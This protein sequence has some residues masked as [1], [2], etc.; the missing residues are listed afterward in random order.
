MTNP[1]I[2]V[3]DWTAEGFYALRGVGILHAR[4]LRRTVKY[5]IDTSR[6]GPSTHMVV[7]RPIHTPLRPPAITPL[8][9]IDH[10]QL[11]SRP[12]LSSIFTTDHVR[13]N[14][15]SISRSTHYTPHHYLLQHATNRGIGP[16]LLHSSLHRSI[17][18]RSSP[19]SFVSS[20]IHFIPSTSSLL[21]RTPLLFFFIFPSFVPTSRSA[22]GRCCSGRR[23]SRIHA[24]SG[25]YP[26][27]SCYLHSN[28][29]TLIMTAFVFCSILPST[30]HRRA[31]APANFVSQQGLVLCCVLFC[32]CFFVTSSN[33]V[34]LPFFMLLRLMHDEDRRKA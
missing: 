3:R 25:T 27:S 10:P 34:I 29:P 32:Y 20:F 11:P 23:T 31:P 9:G 8:S 6:L 19:L 22:A 17:A 33:V 7:F 16:F 18:L 1:Y 26:F 28:H 5:T 30:V 4:D 13:T 21:T 14:T 2:D 12:L 15:L 24:L